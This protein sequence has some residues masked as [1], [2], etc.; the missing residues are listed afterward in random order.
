MKYSESVMTSNPIANATD[1]QVANAIEANATLLEMQA[2]QIQA[3]R[4]ERLKALA[5]KEEGNAALGRRLGFKD[6]AYIGQMIRGDRPI[7]EK[8]ILTVHSLPGYAGWFDKK[9]DS[10]QPIEVSLDANPDYPSIRRVRFKLSAG[11]SGFGVEYLNEFGPPIVFQRQWFDKRG[12]RPEHLYAFSVV[13]GSMEPGLH[14]G[15]TVVVNTEQSEP[16]DGRVYAVNY[17]GELVVKR[18]IRD[19]GNWWLSSDNPDKSRYPRKKC[20]DGVFIIGEIIHKQS[21]LI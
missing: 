21:E 14:D 6:G 1:N 15:D 10:L 20:H 11:A 17:E 7:T 9:D 19:D 16:R 3:W 2:R 12:L 8:L 18:L 4:I 5:I 13:N